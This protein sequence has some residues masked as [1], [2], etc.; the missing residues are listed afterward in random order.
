[1]SS[2]LFIVMGKDTPL[3]PMLS[4][5]QR[6]RRRLIG[7]IT[8]VIVA[9]IAL[10]LALDS[11]P[12]PTQAVQIVIN[13]SHVNQL[14]LNTSQSVENEDSD[15]PAI[16]FNT[17]K[18]AD[19]TQFSPASKTAFNFD[20]KIESKTTESKTV[21]SKTDTASNI[22]NSTAVGNLKTELNDKTPIKKEM[23]A[24]STGQFIV[25][26]GYFDDEADAKGWQKRLNSQHFSV[27]IE[28]ESNQFSL[29]AGPFSNKIL[30]QKAAT[31]L[32]QKIAA[33]K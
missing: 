5:K 26:L 24:S 30:A 1:M 25:H 17:Q 19:L 29:K 23:N 11:P 7:A 4:E 13:N 16:Q 18:R 33:Q 31:S 8:L 15:G 6:A 2:Q 28:R 21:E 20:D 9:A 10:P 12:P 3:D 27:H 32:R 22:K 14:P